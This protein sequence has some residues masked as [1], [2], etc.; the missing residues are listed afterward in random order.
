MRE[1]APS[2]SVGPFWKYFVQRGA[3]E[4]ERILSGT[5]AGGGGQYGHNSDLCLDPGEKSGFDSRAGVHS[6]DRGD[7]GGRKISA[8]LKGCMETFRAGGG[9]WQ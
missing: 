1:N 4:A 9:F 2:G 6:A 7:S 8:D 5:A 3:F